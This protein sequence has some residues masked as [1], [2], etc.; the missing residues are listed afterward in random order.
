MLRRK[1]YQ[2]LVN[3]KA[4]KTK[5]GLLVTGARQV[6][7][8]T[9]I[10][11]FI[12]AEYKHS[13]YINFY[14]NKLALQAM[15]EANSANDVLFAISAFSSEQLVPG[16]TA[17][18][19]DEIQE[20]DDVLTWMKFLIE[21]SRYDFI[22]SGS[23]L[24]VD[25]FDARSLPVGYLQVIDMYP[26]DYQEFCWAHGV[27][28]EVF[29]RL[30]SSFQTG[31]PIPGFLHTRMMDL[32]YA[33]LMVGGMP[34][35]VNAHIATNDL[36]AVRNSQR[37]IFDLYEHDIA[38]YVE[39]AVEAR[40]IKMVYEAIPAQLNEQN[41][42]FKYSRLGKNLRFANMETA[43]DWLEHA[44]VALSAFR[45]ADPQFPLL[46][47]S[48]RNAFKLFSND[49]GILTSQLMGDIDARLVAHQ[50]A[51]NYGSIFENFAAQ[52]FAAHGFDLFYYYSRKIGE[53]D[54]VI[55]DKMA[56]VTLCEIKSG[57]DYNRHSALRN[58]LKTENYRFE[59][60]Y[61]FC[62]DNCS[63]NGAVS[64]R[65]IYMMGCLV[66]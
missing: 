41:K 20:C 24:G 27:G 21:E 10:N 11:E 45:T 1:A 48:D 6:G 30:D 14:E 29:D 46:A 43:F 25:A 42:R 57:K 63:E 26:L 3:W 40:Q 52:E 12:R 37:A 50:S 47:S 8:T 34:D 51:I 58:L 54:F 33:Y 23:L 15:N 38:K 18:F 4:N 49:V 17:I 2:R 7:K 13:V 36:K 16:E 9:L 56:G 60:A 55:Q 31:E 64:Y 5:Q 53:V 65:P 66:P 22:F 39:D 61:V 59:H 44:G 19:L 62:D 32:F 35:A 28:N